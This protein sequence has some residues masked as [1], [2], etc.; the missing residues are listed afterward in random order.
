MTTALFFPMFETALVFGLALLMHFL[1]LCTR[2]DVFFAVTVEPSFRRTPEAARILRRYRIE[3]WFHA[4]VATGVIMIVN[5]S[6]AAVLLPVGVWYILLG[7]TAAL[8]RARALVLPHAVSPSPVREATLTPRRPGLPGGPV[9]LIGPFAIIASAAVVLAVRWDRL[10]NRFP[11]HWNAALQP[12]GWSVRSAGTVFGPLVI[13]VVMCAVLLFIAYGITRWSRRVNV[14]GTPAVLEERFR[15]IVFKLLLA[16]SY[17]LA[18]GTALQSLL[19]LR[20]SQTLPV[21]ALLPGGLMLAAIVIAI[22][23]LVRV[24]REAYDPGAIEPDQAVGPP[25][26]DHTPDRCWKLGI[27]YFN[28]DDPAL[29]VE[30]RFGIG[31]TVNF[32]NWWSW[33][34]LGLLIVGPVILTIG[35]TSIG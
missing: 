35:M 6:G 17:A 16:S 9:A 31:Y 27:L 23:M 20:A 7:A 12:D 15:G 26:G 19:P 2:P 3:V 21:V 22:V 33:V 32:G 11:V 5:L 25:E 8:V 24:R 29:F 13:G 1:P 14:R 10:P 28:P 30:K 34:L 4:F 18:L